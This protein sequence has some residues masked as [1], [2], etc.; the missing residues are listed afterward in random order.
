MQ[1]LC[2]TLQASHDRALVLTSPG[3]SIF[4]ISLWAQ[5]LPHCFQRAEATEIGHARAPLYV[6]RAQHSLSRQEFHSLQ[7]AVGGIGTRTKLHH[8]NTLGF[9][10]AHL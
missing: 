4:L 9:V 6:F 5:R 2:P 8:L 7:K 10:Q 1:A 3:K